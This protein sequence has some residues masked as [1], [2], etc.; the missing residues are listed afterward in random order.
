MQK[1]ISYLPI[2]SYGV[3]YT[4]QRRCIRKILTHHDPTSN[5][6][7]QNSSLSWQ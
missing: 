3:I 6:S 2:Q 4:F 1:M 7:I 5:K